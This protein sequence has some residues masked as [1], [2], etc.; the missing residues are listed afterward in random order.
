MLARGYTPPPLPDPD[1][2]PP[3]VVVSG[4]ETTE[5]DPSIV[6]DLIPDV[7]V[8]DI[9]PVDP[10]TI[11]DGDLTYAS[12]LLT[13]TVEGDF[14]TYPRLLIQ[15]DLEATGAE[16][17]GNL[18]SS[19]ASVIIENPATDN[20]FEIDPANPANPGNSNP[21]QSTPG[22]KNIGYRVVPIDATGQILVDSEDRMLA[23]PW[24]SIGLKLIDP[25]EGAVRVVDID[26]ASDTG[27]PTDQQTQ[28]PRIEV[29]VHGNFVAS[30]SYRLEFEY[31]HDGQTHTD[32]VDVPEIGTVNY[33]PLDN[34]PDLAYD[35][36]TVALTYRL[37]SSTD[38]GTTW[39]Q[40]STD[41]YS[42]GNLPILEASIGEI[43]EETGD[44]PYRGGDRLVSGFLIDTVQ[45]NTVPYLVD[46][47]IGT[48]DEN[49]VVTFH[50]DGEAAVR[51]DETEER[52]EYSHVVVAADSVVQVRAR[53]KQWVLGEYRYSPWVVTTVQEL[54]SYF[55]KKQNNES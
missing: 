10:G 28:D 51:F 37:M 12:P 49:G 52:Y 40:D 33:N 24:E 18:F 54:N 23:S 2:T 47:E 21:F 43:N 32:H 9:D 30:N 55:P 50:E 20:T 7:R 45:D 39:N 34:N 38:G 41:L 26:L 11:V 36:V 17:I 6:S 22:W 53:V 25:A 3:P 5:E 19:D 14:A 29:V 48:P 16:V 1:P 31:S 27:D 8:A 44:T 46:L 4:P 15:S 42:F 35:E 13:G